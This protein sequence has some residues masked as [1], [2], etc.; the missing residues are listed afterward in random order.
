MLILQK[1]EGMVEA[2]DP[3]QIY[4][5]HK[6]ITAFFPYAAWQGQ[7]GQ[8]KMLNTLLNAARASKRQ[9][10]MWHRIKHSITVVLCGEYPIPL[11]QAVI[12]A[13]PHLPWWIPTIDGQF[14]QLWAATAC[15]VPYTPNIGQSVVDTLLLIASQDSLQPHIPVGMWS[16]LNNCTS[17]PPACMGG[18][19]GTKRSVVQAVR[20]LRDIKILTSYLLLVWSEWDYLSPDGLDEMCALIREDFCG[21]GMEYYRKVLIQRLGHTLGR[22]DLGLGYIQQHEQGLGEDDIQS[23]KGQYGQ[24]KGVLIEVDKEATDILTRE[25]QIGYCFQFTN[26]NGYVQGATQCSCVE[27][28]SYV[29]NYMSGCHVTHCVATVA[30]SL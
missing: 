26:S 20:A 11:K 16:W 15:A 25:S 6:A 4:T 19:Q 1:L 9:G 29:C 3:D 8:N 23:M 10:F 22:L 30:L 2:A 21:V 13:S 5:K 17:L 24:L 27:S 14:I 28:L 12:L 7:S 18:S